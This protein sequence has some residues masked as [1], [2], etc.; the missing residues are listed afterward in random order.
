M[1]SSPVQGRWSRTEHGTTTTMMTATVAKVDDDDDT[2]YEPGFDTD[3]EGILTEL[4]A[5]IPTNITA[6][7][8]IL[9]EGHHTYQAPPVPIG[10]QETSDGR[11]Q[12]VDIKIENDLDYPS[13]GETLHPLT[14]SYPWR[15]TDSATSE[16]RRGDQRRGESRS[17]RRRRRREAI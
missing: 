10:K 11:R 7:T 16:T 15:L 1:E 6:S 4:L 8:S 5:R 14:S 2:D 13:I 9:D 12:W 17:E 3:D